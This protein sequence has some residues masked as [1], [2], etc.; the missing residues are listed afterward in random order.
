MRTRGLLIALGFALAAA[1]PAAGRVQDHSSFPD[2]VSD[3]DPDITQVTVASNAAGGITFVV[4][5]GNRQ[6]LAEN[7][8]LFVLIDTDANAATGAAPNGIDAVLQLTAGSA[9]LFRWN[10]SAF[11]DA[12]SQTVYGY[13]YKGFRIAV[14]KR[15][16]GLAA[17]TFNFWVETRSGQ[18][19]DDAPD[20]RIATH[21][22]SAKPLALTVR[23]FGAPRTVRAGS[24]F[25]VAMR[26]YRSDLEELTS[27]GGVRCTARYGRK[28]VKV[29]AA[30]PDDVAGC[31]GTAPRA[32]KRKTLTVTLTL[33]LDGQRV[34]RAASIRVR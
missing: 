8:F 3:G 33:E 31:V 23:G 4:Q 10:G 16:L 6:Q 13:V 20:G 7:E 34:T 17:G 9:D 26:V 11:A 27:A 25:V 21:T 14:N 32:A 24:R 28:A 30:F 12:Q 19:A 5:L 2:A 15:D 29:Q 22:L 1:T 18:K